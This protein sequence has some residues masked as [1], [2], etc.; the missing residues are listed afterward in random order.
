[1]GS[2]QND[3]LGGAGVGCYCTERI[4][5]W[6]S[7][8]YIFL[9]FRLLR[10][11]EFTALASFVVSAFAFCVL[12]FCALWVFGLLTFCL[13]VENW[14]SVIL[15]YWEE[16]HAVCLHDDHPT[17]YPLRIL[18]TLFSGLVRSWDSSAPFGVLLVNN[19]ICLLQAN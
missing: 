12:R 15:K 13:V 7:P 19:N 2:G 6:I 1:M 11:P 9:P 17:P 4:V 16:A 18:A 8:P 14:D 10:F 5:P 3:G